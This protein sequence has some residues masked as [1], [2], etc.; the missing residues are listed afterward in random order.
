MEQLTIRVERG[1]EVRPGVFTYKA[2]VLGAHIGG[3]SRQP[4]LDA[5][6]QIKTL[7]TDT[8]QV[9]ASIYREGRDEPDMSC[10]VDWGA[11]HRVWEGNDG[12]PRFVLFTE[13]PKGEPESA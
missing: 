2:D 4:L 7:L 12:P 10:S 5:C 3:Q 13:F 11:A 1:A 8:W 9:W 6:R